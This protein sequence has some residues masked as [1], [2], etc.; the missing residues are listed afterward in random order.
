VRYK[1]KNNS[2]SARKNVVVSIRKR[3]GLDTNNSALLSRDPQTRV[4]HEILAKYLDSWGGIIVHPLRKKLQRDWHF[5]YIDCFAYTGRYLGESEDTIQHIE[6][7]TVFGSP[8]IGINAL[9]KLADYALNNGIRIRTNSILIERNL[10][11]FQELQNTLSI[12]SLNH[13]VRVT[14]N[15]SSLADREIAVVNADCL[16]LLDN[17]LGY[18]TKDFTWSFYLLDPHGPSGIPHDFVQPIVQ[19]KHH[20]V[21]INFMYEDFIRKAGMAIKNGLKSQHQKLVDN[22]T[23]VF[24]NDKWQEIVRETTSEIQ[25]HRYWRDYVLEGIPL[26]DMEEGSLLTDKQLAEI[27]ERKFVDLYED[28]LREM[29]PKLVIKLIP[30]KFPSREQTMFYLFLTTHD[31]TGALTMNEVLYKAKYR[32]HDLRQRYIVA[33]KS[34][35]PDHQLPL[36]IYKPEIPKSSSPSR[37]VKVEDLADLIFLKFT[38]RT[39]TR[40]EVY[41]QMVE[42]YFFPNEIDNALKHLKITSKATF[43]GN[44]V[45]ETI[46]E[47]AD[48]S[49]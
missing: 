17:L 39:V 30:I 9:D 23:A 12:K 38:G 32:E 37:N 26:D 36:F 42:T 28:V 16:T 48:L 29:D 20:D 40:R 49:I 46:I 3:I 25:A 2:R 27:K 7:Q 10:E 24:N 31:P 14:T 11:N 15:F 35:P 19:Q 43:R 13:R 22:W 4:K 5:I 47:F 21:M 45:H 18:T 34:A 41:R 6:T 8:V 44:L 1:V 33:K